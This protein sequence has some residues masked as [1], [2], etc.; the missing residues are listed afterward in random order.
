M[1]NN[2]FILGLVASV[3]VSAIV[4]IFSTFGFNPVAMLIGALVTVAVLWAIRVLP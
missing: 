2:G 4:L 1:K 3:P